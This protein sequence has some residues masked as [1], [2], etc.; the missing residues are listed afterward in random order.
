M[1]LTA[2]RRW[3]YTLMKVRAERF[4]PID[5]ASRRVERHARH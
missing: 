4:L 2:L 5:R 1:E 3:L